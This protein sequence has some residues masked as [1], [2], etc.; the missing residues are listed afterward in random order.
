MS[1]SCVWLTDNQYMYYILYTLEFRHDWHICVSSNWV[2]PVKAC[3]LT[4]LCISV[5]KAL[6]QF[7]SHM[8]VF[9][10]KNEQTSATYI[11][12]RR[13]SYN[14][15]EGRIQDTRTQIDR[16]PSEELN[17]NRT[18]CS[19]YLNIRRIAYERQQQQTNT[20]ICITLWTRF[21]S[22]FTCMGWDK[23]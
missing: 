12:I 7:D 14:I 6:Q 16:L 9:S 3:V 8:K 22:D 13:T 10:K 17:L 21:Q 1:N 15:K 19:N 11:Q 18:Y 4:S 23:R 2:T 5:H 20:I